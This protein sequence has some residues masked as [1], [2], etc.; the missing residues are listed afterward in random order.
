MQTSRKWF[1]DRNPV[2]LSICPELSP[3][4]MGLRIGRVGA[5][6]YAEDPALGIP[7]SGWL[8]S[9]IGICC[10]LSTG[11]Y[12]SSNFPLTDAWPDFRIELLHSDIF[13]ARQNCTAGA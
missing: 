11:H 8:R 10:L 6:G 3:T 13:L 9:D 7:E 4:G 5:E 12:G 1:Q 2:R